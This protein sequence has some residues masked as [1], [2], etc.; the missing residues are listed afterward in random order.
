MGIACIN[1]DFDKQPTVGNINMQQ[2]RL[3][4]ATQAQGMRK[5]S[6]LTSLQPLCSG[7]SILGFPLSEKRMK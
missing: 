6:C 3:T 5:Q 1:I 7:G 4:P 2:D